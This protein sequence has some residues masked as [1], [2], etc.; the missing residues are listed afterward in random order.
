[1]QWKA[2]SL[3]SLEQLLREAVN[4]ALANSLPVGT[5]VKVEILMPVKESKP[6]LSRELIAQNIRCFLKGQMAAQNK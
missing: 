1:M 5:S 4:R 3:N 6:E 2:N